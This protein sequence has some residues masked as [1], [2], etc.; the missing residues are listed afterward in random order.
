M[1]SATLGLSWTGSQHTGCSTVSILI[2]EPAMELQFTGS[3]PFQT[4][5]YVFGLDRTQEQKVL[6]FLGLRS[7]LAGWHDFTPSGAQK[8]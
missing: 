6:G 5:L 1:S 4:T 2:A 3:S 7:E 8:C